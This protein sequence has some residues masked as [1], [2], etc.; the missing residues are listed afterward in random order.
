MIGGAGCE[1]AEEDQSGDDT[2]YFAFK[3]AEEHEKNG[4]ET[5]NG[6]DGDISDDGG[7]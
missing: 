6:A 4:Y 3:V 2:G 1:K 7:R 5:S